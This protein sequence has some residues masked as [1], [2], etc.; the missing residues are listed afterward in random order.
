MTLGKTI[1]ISRRVG[2][3]LKSYMTPRGRYALVLLHCSTLLCHKPFWKIHHYRLS[4][5]IVLLLQAPGKFTAQIGYRHQWKY[6]PMTK[7]Q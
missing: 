6:F 5:V 4:V 2:I 7:P 3:T 1:K